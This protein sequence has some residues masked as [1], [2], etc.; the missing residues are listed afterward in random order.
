LA[1]AIDALSFRI[2]P[3]DVYSL[4]GIVLLTAALALGPAAGALVATVEG[5]ASGVLLIILYNRPRSFYLMVA[6]PFMRGGVRA[7]GILAGAALA[8]AATGRPQYDP[9][10]LDP[11]A[12]LP[13]T[14]ITYTAA[15]QLSRMGREALQGGQSGV[16]TWWRST[17]RLALGAELAPLPLALLGAAIYTRLGSVYFLLAGVALVAAATAVR[18]ATLNL[19]SQR[20]SVRELALLNEVSRAI[21]RSE[22]DVETLCELIYREASKIVDTSSFH[23]GLFEGGSYTLAV[24]VQDRVRLPQLTVDLAD[25]DGL[26]GWMRQT[27]RALLVEDFAEEMRHLPARPRYQSERPPR[28]GIYVPLIAGDHV[29]GSISVQSYQPAAFGA[30]DLRLLSL[31]ADQAAVAITRARAFREA[32]VRAVQLQAIRQVS[33]RITAILDL[34]RLLPAVVRLIREHFGY[35]PIHIFTIEPDDPRIHFRAST[36]TGEQLE[37]ILALPLTVGQ[38]IVG[39]VAIEGT[40]ILVGD[41]H[42]E[43]RYIRDSRTTRSELAVPLRVGDQVVGVLDVQSDEVDDFDADD[44][45]VIRTLADQIAV[46]IDSAN[47]Y[48]A[49]QEEAWTLN[50]LLQ[51]AENIGRAASIDDLIAT[52]VRLPPLLIGAP[53]SYVLLWDQQEGQFSLEAAHGLRPEL[54]SL[55][56]G[57][58]VHPDQAPL[59][60]ELRRAGSDGRRLIALDGARARAEQWPQLLEVA[61]GGCLI[62]MPLVGRVGLLGAFILDYDDDAQLSGRQINLCVGAAGQVSGALESLLLAR[63][64]EAAARLEQELQVAREIQTALLP[65]SSPSI[66]GWQIDATWR[67][68][69]L[70][71]GDF[72]DFWPMPVRKDEGERAMG[73]ALV[74]REVGVAR[75]GDQPAEA[76]PAAHDPQPAALGFVIADV[77][78]KGVPAA[79]FMAL[80]RSLVRAAALDGSPPSQAMERANRWITRDSESG[81]FVTLFYGVLD[82]QSGRL[83]YTVAGHNPP[84]HYRAADG[85]MAELRTPGIALGVLEEIKLSEA[86]TD[87]APGDVLVCYTDGVTET[88]DDANEEFGVERLRAL[89]VRRH[90]EPAEAIVRAIIDAVSR[91]GHGRPPFDDVTLVV[92]KREV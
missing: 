34:D 72:F 4:G 56:L 41:V 74:A 52:A 30:N 58:P 76:Q 40:P 38:G 10:T 8:T 65:A 20:R 28:S 7:A 19:A 75:R 80:S 42:R 53:R 17:W 67:S 84:L 14:I 12:L 57:Q 46:A 15:L 18:R 1:L 45:F 90:S 6:R 61:G 32:S 11:L 25:G 13:W 43:P 70:V 48:R 36:S 60:A 68:A 87:L 82:P 37:Q 78:D 51:V 54:R 35:H 79:M 62:A 27:G 73:E 26:I 85:G 92:L 49:Q 91:H 29:I 9:A 77:S 89:L 2:P 44:M 33:E 88:I 86:Q 5:L 55:L 24:R 66:P 59:L 63:E 23:L 50:A 71:G 69:R 31:I 83:R 16:A 21:I 64:A 22:L 47:S 3:A 81:M 39:A